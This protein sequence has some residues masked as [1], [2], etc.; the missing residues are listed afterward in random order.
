MQNVLYGNSIHNELSSTFQ[1]NARPLGSL[2]RVVLACCAHVAGFLGKGKIEHSTR[3]FIVMHH[4]QD[5]A[6]VGTFSCFLLYFLGWKEIL[7]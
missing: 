6:S 4:L 1:S 2:P 7:L 3:T 5:L